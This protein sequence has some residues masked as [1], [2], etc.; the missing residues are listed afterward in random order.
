[1]EL[2]K[3]LESLSLVLVVGYKNRPNSI[4]AKLQTIIIV[5]LLVRIGYIV[6]G[7]GVEKWDLRNWC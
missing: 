6:Y 2:K 1:L 7:F 3:I 5:S 4:L